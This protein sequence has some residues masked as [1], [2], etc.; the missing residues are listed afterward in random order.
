MVGRFF[1]FLHRLSFFLSCRAKFSRFLL[2]SVKG[3]KLWVRNPMEIISSKSVLPHKF[4]RYVVDKEM[5]SGFIVPVLLLIAY[6]SIS[7]YLQVVKVVVKNETAHKI[8]QI[9]FTVNTSHIVRTQ[10]WIGKMVVFS[11][12][13][14]AFGKMFMLFNL[15]PRF[16]RF[17]NATHTHTVHQMK[18]FQ[19]N[20]P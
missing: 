8:I 17:T 4:K 15:W 14:M 19:Q 13:R 10:V 3:Q 20:P 9:Y 7:H 5:R 12:L 6:M 1:T 11:M 2:A 18:E 16:T